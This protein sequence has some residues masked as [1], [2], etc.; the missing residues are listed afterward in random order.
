MQA[1]SSLLCS[2]N[3]AGK[4]NVNVMGIGGETLA[5]DCQQSCGLITHRESLA[6]SLRNGFDK[7]YD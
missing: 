1:V 4:K 2:A 7:L 3:R 5:A 6:V